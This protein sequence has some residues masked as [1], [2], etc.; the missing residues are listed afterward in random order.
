L[1]QELLAL[2]LAAWRRLWFGNVR[3]VGSGHPEDLGRHELA[4]LLP[5]CGRAGLFGTLH[6]WLSHLVVFM[7][8]Q[9]F[10]Q[11]RHFFGIFLGLGIRNHDRLLLRA[12]LRAV[13]RPAFSMPVAKEA[14][15]LA[16]AP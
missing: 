1:A 4:P 12:F 6:G 10:P 3:A 15:F 7:L 2:P 16:L 9:A 13:R 8:R 14:C 5:A 11:A